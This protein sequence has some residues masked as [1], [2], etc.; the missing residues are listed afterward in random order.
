M[1]RLPIKKLLAFVLNKVIGDSP[2]MSYRNSDFKP[3]VRHKF[4]KPTSEQ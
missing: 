2:M 1:K 3:P 4:G